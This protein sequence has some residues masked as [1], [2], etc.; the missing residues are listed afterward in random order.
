MITPIH[1]PEAES[2]KAARRFAMP[3]WAMS[4]LV[5]VTI[6]VVLAI[7]IRTTPRGAASEPSRSG[8]IVLAE[9]SDG[10][11]EYVDGD[12]DDNESAASSTSTADSSLSESLPSVDQPP[13]DMAGFL[14]TGDAG[15]AAS[16]TSGLPSASGLTG[17]GGGSKAGLDGAGKTRVFGI[18]GTGSK[19]AYVFDR[20]G[21]MG[22]SAGRPLAAAKSELL[23]SLRDLDK[24][25]QFQII[26]YN[27]EPR[28]FNPLGG[29]PRLMFADDQGKALA[30]QF[31]GSISATGGTN[32]LKALHMALQMNA[33]V[34][35]FLTDADG[36]PTEEEM[37]DI[38]RRNRSAVINTI[39]FG[40]GPWDGRRNFLV[41][42]AEE[43]GGQHA[44]VDTSKLRPRR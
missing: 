29:T 40:V 7:T 18:E 37:A 14:P 6:I 1:P 17:G 33:D 31:V 43:N 26:F 5:H 11:T 41:R 24:L 21:S 4:M 42:L 22:N 2:E 35:F 28:V 8:G 30:E 12:S 10:R 3:A 13:L 27:E 36:S 19:F 39:E 16:Q 32:H 15:D 25:H 9:R 44:Y 34:I 20:S 23:T 38:R